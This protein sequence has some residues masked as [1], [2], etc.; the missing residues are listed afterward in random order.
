MNIYK[1]SSTNKRLLGL[2]TGDNHLMSLFF[3]DKINLEEFYDF[4]YGEK[5]E[6]IEEMEHP[7][8]EWAKD[9][10]GNDLVL[11]Y[12]DLYQLIAWEPLCE[13]GIRKM[14]I[15]LYYP[16]SKYLCG[17]IDGRKSHLDISSPNGNSSSS[18]N[19]FDGYL[20]FQSVI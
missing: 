14:F 17:Y 12:D 11:Y 3:T 18:N 4:K 2:L 20:F 15:S 5:R 1:A 16:F 10:K 8:T 13:Q 19:K 7:F 9:D 6:R